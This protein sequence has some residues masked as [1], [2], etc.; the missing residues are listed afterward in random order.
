M[1][2]VKDTTFYERLGIETCSSHWGDTRFF[3]V[4]IA[5]FKQEMLN[6]YKEMCD[7]KENG[8]AEHY[9]V[10]LSRKYRNDKRFIFK[11]RHQVVFNGVSGTITSEQLAAGKG[12]QNS[13]KMRMKNVIHLVL[14][15]IFPKWLI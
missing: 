1:G 2:D 4:Q 3:V 6:A 11:Y 12:S 14:R 7:Y 8:W 15:N 10:R 9:M 13:L 5:F